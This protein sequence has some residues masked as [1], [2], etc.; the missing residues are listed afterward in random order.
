MPGP[1]IAAKWARV[2]CQKRSIVHGSDDIV[3]LCAR[4]GEARRRHALVLATTSGST[5]QSP[6]VMRQPDPHAARRP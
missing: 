1:K 3:D 6:S 4:R 2:A 5:G